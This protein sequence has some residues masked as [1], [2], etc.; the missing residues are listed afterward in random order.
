MSHFDRL[1]A[2]I[3]VDEAR[4]RSE[5]AAVKA[6]SARYMIYMT[7]RTGS[8]WLRDLLRSTDLLGW[9]EEWFNTTMLN[10]F[11]KSINANSVHAYTQLHLGR[12]QSPNG[13]YGATIT[14]H[15][16]NA[17]WPDAIDQETSDYF[18]HFPVD[19]TRAFML[20]RRDIVAQAISLN[21][22]MTTGVFD[23]VNS[24]TET[25]RRSEGA[26]FYDERAI[27]R[28]LHQILEHEKS[29]L[30]FFDHHGITP[31]RLVYEELTQSPVEEVIRYF[32]E[33]V[34]P[35]SRI[36][37]A[38]E[39]G[40]QHQKIAT[41]KNHAFA[42]RF[43]LDNTSWLDEIE[44]ERSS[45]FENTDSV[46]GDPLPSLKP[47]DPQGASSGPIMGNSPATSDGGLSVVVPVYAGLKSVQK[48]LTSV[49]ESECQTPYRLIVIY[50]GGPDGRIERYLDILSRKGLIELH[51]NAENLGFV[52]T[53]NR[54]FSLAG[55]DDVI[56]LNS[57]TEVPKGWADRMARA[58]RSDPS[59]ATATPFTNNGEICSY[60]NLCEV[61][62]IPPGMDVQSMD[63]HVQEWAS[64]QPIDIPTGVGFCLYISRAALDAFGPFDEEAFGRGYGEETDFCRRAADAGWRNVLL[65]NIFV[66]HEGGL[67]FGDEKK[68]R[69]AYA[70]KLLEKRH[71]GYNRL[72]EN[73]CVENP[74][75]PVRFQLVLKSLS[76]SNLPVVLIIGHGEGGGT[77]RFI[78]EL[79]YF[80][81]EKINFLWIEPEGDECVRLVFPDWASSYTQ[82]Y[83]LEADKDQLFDSIRAAGVDLVHINHIRGI[84]KFTPELL[85]ELGVEHLITLH[86]YYFLGS[87]PSLIDSEGRYDPDR[88]FIDGRPCEDEFSSLKETLLKTA[89]ALVTPSLEAAAIYKG[90]HPD[91]E[92]RV[93]E[94]I[95]TELIPSLPPVRVKNGQAN[96][97]KRVLI[98]G[99]LGKEKGADLL[100][101]AAADAKRRGLPIEFHLVGYAYRVLDDSVITHGP[102]TEEAL[103]QK[104][105]ELKPD[106]IWFPCQWPETYS[107]T[108]TSAMEAG[109]PLLVPKIGAFASRTDGRPYTWYF[110][111]DMDPTRQLK[112]IERCLSV[113]AEKGGEV[114]LW[115]PQPSHGQAY[116]SDDHY[117]PARLERP[118]TPLPLSLSQEALATLFAP[119]HR[120]ASQKGLRRFIAP[121]L[122]RLRFNRALSQFWFDVLPEAARGRLRR[123]LLGR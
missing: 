122:W 1:L 52:R 45:I 86:D 42:D 109:V 57:D 85:D 25:R 46:T 30:R 111:Y 73:Y 70:I 22:M 98:L 100:Q 2:K 106:L 31:H 117:V 26:F 92:I 34:T 89:K 99:A 108:L 102:Y 27:R 95:G 47:T 105:A 20:F 74:V 3:E 91:L 11:A 93:Q 32:V 28:C 83:N 114:A 9:P 107:Y 33:V 87:S 71:P 54:G 72:I 16:L 79:R 37:D 41:S 81:R 67:S 121:L 62:P 82:I 75:K 50:D 118:V 36:E 35:Q 113:L 115:A 44:D 104:I 112:E 10:A 39:A 63:D 80:F 76:S 88:Y 120:D 66:Y 84:E 60:P 5:L 40:S 18:T 116:Y 64:E 61:N 13:V 43:R 55:T 59:I 17:L 6:P 29:L 68:A 94:H 19:Q 7:P 103:Q 58:A 119:S 110:P 12:G 53:A 38:R 21:R 90:V 65:T 4:L 97:P 8:S 24:T 56:I 51:K 48:C 96:K 101:A 23:T 78:N 49:L 14:W 77:R 123:Y 69:V 15:D